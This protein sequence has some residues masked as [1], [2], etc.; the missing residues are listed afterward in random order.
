MEHLNL[1]S[2]H[3]AFEKNRIQPDNELTRISNK[4]I[5]EGRTKAIN[6]LFYQVLA[7]L[8]NRLVSWGLRLQAYQDTVIVAK[9]DSSPTACQVR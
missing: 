6:R 1:E 4:F 7:A 8:G 9:S 5:M 2:Y 3:Y